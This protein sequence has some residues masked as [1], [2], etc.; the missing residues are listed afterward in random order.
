MQLGE[1]N[2]MH[3]REHLVPPPV[4]RETDKDVPEL[5]AMASL[6][7]ALLGTGESYRGKPIV[8]SRWVFHVKHHGTIQAFT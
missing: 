8:G 3:S 6:R 4:S 5:I 7:Q 2:P 1:N